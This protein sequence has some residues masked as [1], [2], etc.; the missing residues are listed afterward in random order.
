[1]TANSNATTGLPRKALRWL[2]LPGIALALFYYFWLWSPMPS[3]EE[4][5]ANFTAHR[6]DFVEVVRRYR[7]YPR[8]PDKD[9]SFWFK[10][11][12]TLA[13]YKLAGIERVDYSTPVWLPNPYS[14]ETNKKV[15]E[16][17]KKSKGFELSHKYG[18]LEI[19][20]VR[21]PRIIDT[22]Q[23]NRYRWV[24]LTYGVI[25]KD[26][27]F[28]PEAPR[29]EH[30]LLLGPVNHQG[31]YSFRSRVLP[32]LNRLPFPWRD[33]ECVYRQIEPQWFLRI[34]NGH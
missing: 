3:D 28:F 25:W 12:D 24:G 7:D 32:S 1:V 13:L 8:P 29:I 15:A 27:Y 5:I 30:G 10:E 34:C 17:R 23:S 22:N 26:Y 21:T 18:A 2:W 31:D 9:T 6:E 16:E 14:L 33:F 4:M 20:P 11:G 19:T